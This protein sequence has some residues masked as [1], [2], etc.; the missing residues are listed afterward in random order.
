MNSTKN[1]K[2]ENQLTAIYEKELDFVEGI[3]STGSKNTFTVDLILKKKINE[4]EKKNVT[5]ALKYV[6]CNILAGNQY[7]EISTININLREYDTA[8]HIYSRIINKD[9]CI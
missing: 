1:N 3:S 2:I 7:S 4:K 5:G 9:K 8:D 6:T